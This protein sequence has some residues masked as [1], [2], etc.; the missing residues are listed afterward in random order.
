MQ[1]GKAILSHAPESLLQAQPT[2]RTVV[3]IEFMRLNMEEGRPL[4]AKYLWLQLDRETL[5]GSE[6]SWTLACQ[7]RI[8]RRTLIRWALYRLYGAEIR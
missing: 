1:E 6:Q 8:F 3:T 2:N 4:R 7:R 5:W